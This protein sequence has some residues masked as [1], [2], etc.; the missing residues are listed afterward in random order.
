MSGL[1][2]K[3]HDITTIIAEGNIQYGNY[4]KADGNYLTCNGPSGGSSGINPTPG[5][6]TE[7]YRVDGE[8]PGGVVLPIIRVWHWYY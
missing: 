6:V 2:W 8:F 5:D 4:K 7:A 3:G 1:Y